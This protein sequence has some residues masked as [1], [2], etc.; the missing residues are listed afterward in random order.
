MYA[1][2]RDALRLLDMDG[3]RYG[4]A[5]WNPL[6]EIVRPGDNVLVKPNLVLHFNAG[7]G[8]L[9]AIVTHP[10]VIRAVVDFVLVALDG[11]G[12][13]VVG[14][15]PQANC[16]FEALSAATGLGQLAEWMGSAC[17]DRGV[18]FRLV[19]FRREKTTLRRGVVWERRPLGGRAPVRVR[20]GA[21]SA[22]GAIDNARLYGAD[23]DRRQT[24]ASHV[25]REHEYGVAAE[26]LESDVV[27]SIPKL[28]VHSKVGT[29]L[30]LKNMVGVAV[31]KNALAHYR[32]GTACDGGDEREAASWD[33]RVDRLLTDW[34]LGRAPRGG[35]HGFLAWRAARKA[36]RAIGLVRGG[37]MIGSGD[38][39]G[40]DTAWRMALDLNRIV[41]SGRADGSIARVPVRRV[42]SIVDGIV[43]GDGEGPLGATPVCSGV[44]VGGRNP[45]SVD[46]VATCAMGLDPSRMPLYAQAAEI[47]GELGPGICQPIR[48]LAD[49][50]EWRAI[51]SGKTRVATFRPPRG[52]RGAIERTGVPA[53]KGDG[54]HDSG[55]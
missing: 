26:L 41:L 35:R 39:H 32:I 46:W 14:D 2:V 44:I 5:D 53:N 24:V 7:G 12:Q 19:D 45:L 9:D 37:S 31:D 50:S 28:K 38:W 27:V 30:N 29:T 47:L 6:G 36:L 23:Y 49:V 34:L 16:D 43:G 10:S 54:R 8:S 40:N 25:S 51:L 52:W 55:S 3:E 13:I 18:G 21:A 4:S 48:V 17:R 22:I 11:R 1:A 42:F 33:D 20:L 15:A